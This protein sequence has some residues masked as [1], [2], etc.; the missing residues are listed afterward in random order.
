MKDINKK[1]KNVLPKYY[2]DAK[3]IKVNSIEKN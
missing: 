3:N 2:Y 1:Y